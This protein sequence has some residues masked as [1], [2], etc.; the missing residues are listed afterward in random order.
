MEIGSLQFY[1]LVAWAQ[2]EKVSSLLDRQDVFDHF[3]ILFNQK[4][5]AVVFYPLGN[6]L[7]P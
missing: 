3:N 1:C 4:R 6:F 5:R 7:V 2:T